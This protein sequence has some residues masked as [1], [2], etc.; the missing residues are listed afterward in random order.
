MSKIILDY[1]CPIG[2]VNIINFYTKKFYRD[3]DKIYL[4]ENISNYV[5]N[6]KKTSFLNFPKNLFLRVNKLRKIFKKYKNTKNTKFFLLSYDP[7]VM[8]LLS[9]VINLKNFKFFLIE[10][11]NLNPK[12]KI[13]LLFIYLL[14]KNFYHLVYV[15]SAKKFLNIKFNK[16]NVYQT[17]LPLIHDTKYGKKIYK[18]K[19]KLALNM[20][21][22]NILI[23]TRHHFKEELILKISKENIDCDFT[24][25]M[26]LSNIKKKLFKN[27]ININVL[28][29]ISDQDL[30]KFNG[31]YLPLDETVYRYRISA[32]L[33]KAILFKKNVI[34]E[35]NNLYKFEKSRFPNQIISYKNKLNIPLKKIN[36]FI[37]FK[38]YNQK[39]IKDLKKIMY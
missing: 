34:M 32:W 26:K 24:V 39:L 3:F 4:N 8:F 20:K 15:D 11:D 6:N 22:I 9:K 28:E 31:I 23:P 18:K 1:Q 19:N 14:P 16:K 7:L 10:H 21:K 35:S 17:N 29:K 2:H 37:D 25:L 27:I 33:Y 5:E 36:I 38:K 13:R 30:K 12:K